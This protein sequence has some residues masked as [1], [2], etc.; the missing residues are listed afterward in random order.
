MAGAM[1]AIFGV[2]TLSFFQNP[3]KKS[4]GKTQPPKKVLDT[5]S[6]SPFL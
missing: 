5:K 6:P 3:A 4:Y 2:P 1:P